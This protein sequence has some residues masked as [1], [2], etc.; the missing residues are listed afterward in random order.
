MERRAK[1]GTYYRQVGADAWE[2]V[3]RQ[4]KDGTSYKKV[5]PDDWAPIEQAKPKQ[6]SGGRARAALEG[7]ADSVSLGTLPY[8]KAAGEVVSDFAAEELLGAPKTETSFSDRVDRARQ[9]G[10]ELQEKAPGYAMAG[11]LGGFVLPGAAASKA[12]GAGLKAASTV[13]KLARAAQFAQGSS[14]AGQGAKLAAEGALLGAAYTPESGFTDVESRLKSAATGAATGAVMPAAMKGAGKVA[15]A[16]GEAAKSASKGLGIGARKLLGSIGGVSDDVIGRYLKDPDRINKAATFEELYDEVTG[17]VGRM[18]SD[19]DNA[20]IDAAAAKAHLDDV[21][22]GIK[23]SRIEGKAKALEEVS[24]ARALV[25]EAFKAQKQGLAERGS[26]SR[27]EPLVADAIE[28]QR[29][30]VTQG[31][32]EAYDILGK[33]DGFVD[34]HKVLQRVR[35]I[36]ESLNVAGIGPA[37]PQAAAAQREIDTLMNTFGRLPARLSLPEA[38]KLI[39]QI[40]RAEKVVYGQGQFTDD[41]GRAFKALRAGVDEQLKEI[42]EYAAQMAKVADDTRLLS[43]ANKQ[44]GGE[45]ARLSRLSNISRPTARPD[46]NTLQ[47]L[48]AREGGDMPRAVSELVE[49]QR[50]LKSP[51]RLES[52]KGRLPE[53]SQ[54]R[55]A[56]MT[57]AVTKRMAKPGEIRSA[58]ERSAAFYKKRSADANLKTAQKA[59]DQFKAFG[60]QTA[61]SKLKSV[62]QGKI[63][64]TR[65]LQELSKLSDTDFVEA[66]KAAQDAAAFARPAFNGSRNVNLWAMLGA[67]GQAATGKTGAG[68]AAGGIIGGPVGVAVG[69]VMG[70]MVDA[71]GPAMTKKILDGVISIRGPITPKALQALDLPPNVKN[72]LVKQFSSVVLAGRAARSAA[73]SAIPRAAQAPPP[74]VPSELDQDSSV[75]AWHRKEDYE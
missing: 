37:T 31:S 55:S 53:S 51:T 17:I 66:V 2:P 9:Q 64:A 47:S 16:V 74:Q 63:K 32:A 67:L 30:R 34:M 27:L 46:L 19:L 43:T 75:P 20:K 73:E 62:A 7:F 57:A 8:L 49:A 35:P 48:A 21:A 65:T 70:A 68:A 13:P 69:G 58:I 18:A 11:Q 36:K 40:D 25:D 10:K 29:N 6:E 5:G 72:E 38:K 12:V 39:Q 4:A 15:G 44:F 24:R 14:L 1:D 28:N 42:P 23:E 22:R 3:T 54:L 26:P 60:E 71:Y 45:A 52:I 59:F 61:E 50:T 56:E 33:Q 41:V